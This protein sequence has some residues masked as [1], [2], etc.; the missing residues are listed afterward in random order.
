[1]ATVAHCFQDQMHLPRVYFGKPEMTHRLKAEQAS[2]NDREEV[3]SLRVPDELTVDDVSV[4]LF[5][6]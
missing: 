3:R 5:G 4:A 2:R 1:M 6:G